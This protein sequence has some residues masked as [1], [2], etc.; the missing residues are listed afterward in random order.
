MADLIK[1][2]I[3][4]HRAAFDPNVPGAHGWSS[5]ESA[6][7]RLQSADALEQHITINRVLL[8][9]EEPDSCVWE[10]INAQ[11]DGHHGSSD[12]LECFIKQNR[13]ELDDA[14]PPEMVWGNIEKSLPDVQRPTAKIIPV[15]WQRNL[16]RI[17]ASLALLISG[18]G[19]GTWYAR[20]NTES[21]QMADVSNEYA[22][23]EQYYQRDISVKQQKLAS[24]TGNRP[25]EVKMDLEQLDHMMQELR[26][27][28]ADVPPANREQV[29]RAM[30]ENYKAKTAILKR[31]LEDLDTT[32]Q[33][34][35]V[36]S[37]AGYEIKDL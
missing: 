26:K 31:V 33:P 29:V 32:H 3:Q 17:A 8:D 20:Q 1:K 12:L 14:M 36:N 21:M 11:L 37:D 15:N 18:I 7:D 25:V 35:K 9:T 34:D 30:I 28:L 2:F 24:F 5:V 23:L 10:N 4:Q 6:L 27:E 19:I 22:E 16:M 13:D